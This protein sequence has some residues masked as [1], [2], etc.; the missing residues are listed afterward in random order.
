M[1][2]TIPKKTPP[3]THW[4]IYLSVLIVL[5][6]AVHLLLPQLATI[7]KSLAVLKKMTW[8]LVALATLAQGLSYVGSGYI[9]KAILAN[10]KQFLSVWQGM[11]ITLASYSIGLVAGG[12]VG[13]AAATYGWMRK[14]QTSSDS[15]TLA[16]ILPALL[17]DAALTVVS[18]L[19]VIYLFIVHDLTKMQLLGYGLVLVILGGLVLL[20]VLATRRPQAVK[21]IAVRLGSGWAK[22]RHQDHHPE[23]T[24]VS[25]DRILNAWKSLDQGRWIKPTLGAFANVAFDMLTLY[26]VFLAAGYKLNISV[27]FAGY[28]LPL[29]LGKIAF[30]LPGGVGVIEGSMAALFESLKVPSDVAVISILGYRVLSF[31]LPTLLGFIAAAFLGGK[32]TRHKSPKDSPPVSR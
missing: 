7:E 30:I 5:G 18:I 13:G 2:E 14:D 16:S 1:S 17:N 25:V 12:W 19:G 23:Q 24:E 10:R 28:G 31:W 8:W 32:A 22:L 6:L 27:L 4:W 15:A 20:T 3:K 21:R 11:L 9:L 29:M 26:L